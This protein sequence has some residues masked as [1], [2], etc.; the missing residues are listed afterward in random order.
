MCFHGCLSYSFARIFHWSWPIPSG[1][2]KSFLAWL[3]RPFMIWPFPAHSSPQAPSLPLCFSAVGN[4]SPK[5]QTCSAG[6]LFMLFPVLRI[7]TEYSPFLLSFPLSLLSTSSGYHPVSLW[8]FRL[9]RISF[10]NCSI[11]PIP[12]LSFFFFFLMWGPGDLRAP[13]WEIRVF[14]HIHTCNLGPCQSK[15]WKD[16]YLAH[17]FLPGLISESGTEI[18]IKYLPNEYTV[19]MKV[20]SERSPGSC[21]YLFKKWQ[22]WH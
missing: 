18:L 9:Y 6:Q 4:S 10:T 15:V 5:L 16:P 8:G 22:N 11:L 13:L 19:V 14:K 3:L 12:S 7:F 1:E 20:L 21:N 17:C 2:T